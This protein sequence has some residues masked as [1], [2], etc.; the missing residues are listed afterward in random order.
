MTIFQWFIQIQKA[1][2]SVSFFPTI[3]LAPSNEPC[4]VE[5][6]GS[7]VLV[8]WIGVLSDVDLHAL[9]TFLGFSVLLCKM[10]L[11]LL[12]TGLQGGFD[13]PRQAPW[14]TAIDGS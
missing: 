7:G 1:I 13:E 3:A 11:I 9:V 14:C 5:N 4:E 2:L 10:G 6:W 8:S 12:N